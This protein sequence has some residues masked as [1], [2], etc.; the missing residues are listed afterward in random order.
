MNT[1][2]E[3]LEFLQTNYKDITS[4]YHLTQLAIFGSFARD[5]QRED[6]DVD[7]LIEIQDG[8][9]NIHDLKKSLHEYLS[10]SF[11]RNVDIARKKYLKPYAKEFILKDAIYVK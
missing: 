4:K 8:T 5:E 3:I 9:Q 11:K 1:Q 6:S 7:V 2:K 10:S